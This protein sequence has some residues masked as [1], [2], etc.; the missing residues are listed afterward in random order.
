MVKINLVCIAAL[1]TV[2]KVPSKSRGL[3][4]TGSRYYRING[5]LSTQ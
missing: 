4:R 3:I 2:Y 5:Q 1:K